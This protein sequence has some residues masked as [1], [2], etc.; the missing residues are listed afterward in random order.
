[1]V[2]TLETL[3]RRWKNKQ[4]KKFNK[5][6]LH[7]VFEPFWKDLP[8][9]DIFTCITPNILHQLHK[10][11]FHDHLMQWCLGIVGEKEMDACFQAVS[12]YPG[13]HHFKKGIS[14]VSQ[15]TGTE[16]REM[17]R[18]FIGLLSGAA[19]DSVLVMAR[20]LLDFIYYAQFQQQ[21]HKTLAAMQESLNL[22]HSHKAILTKLHI[23]DHF[24][25]PKIH[26]LLH[27]VSSICVLGSADGYN[28]EYPEHLHI[29][30]TK[31][32]YH[33]SNK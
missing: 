24:N 23:W 2:D 6:G 21:M 5:E 19:E 26:S 22:F 25:V 13:L 16:H 4:L 11:I 1:M 17:E 32:A 7:E 29:N 20:S 14:S 9:T 27:Y 31:D 8:F 18:V 30:Y 10:R 15:W 33:A 3:W 28:M 12:Q